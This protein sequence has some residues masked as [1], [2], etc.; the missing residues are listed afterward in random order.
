M[1]SC[2]HLFSIATRYSNVV[3][4]SAAEF[5][6][7]F[8]AAKHFIRRDQITLRQHLQKEAVETVSKNWMLKKLLLCKSCKMPGKHTIETGHKKIR[9]CILEIRKSRKYECTLHT[10]LSIH[11]FARSNQEVQEIAMI[12][13]TSTTATTRHGEKVATVDVSD[14][15]HHP[16]NLF[17]IF[18]PFLPIS[19]HLSPFATFFS[20]LQK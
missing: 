17:S 9:K 13:G 15:L 14:L 12:T 10:Y 19:Y 11:F 1:F 4:D 6:S 8:C 7:D 16:H 20:C 2:D 5:S 3:A 18:L